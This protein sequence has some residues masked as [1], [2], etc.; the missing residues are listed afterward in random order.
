MH[1]AMMNVASAI[2]PGSDMRS[3]QYLTASSDVNGATSNMVRQFSRTQ[4]A[5]TNS[6]NRAKQHQYNCD[7]SKMK[8]AIEHC[9]RTKSQPNNNA[10]LLFAAQRPSPVLSWQHRCQLLRMTTDLASLRNLGRSTHGK[11]CNKRSNKLIRAYAIN[12]QSLDLPE[13]PTRTNC[14][15]TPV[16]E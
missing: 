13:T 3:H 14:M 7:R 1:S 11:H 16:A 10:H 12:R 6:K 8:N 5:T 4:L 15:S 9:K 2:S